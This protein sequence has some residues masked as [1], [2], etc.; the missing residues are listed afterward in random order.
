MTEVNKEAAAVAPVPLFFTV[1][2]SALCSLFVCLSVWL[3]LVEPGESCNVENITKYR[4]CMPCISAAVVLLLW[5]GV[6][7]PR[8]CFF[9]MLVSGMLLSVA[10]YLLFFMICGHESYSG[11]LVSWLLGAIAWWGLSLIYS[12]TRES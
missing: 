11:L 5:V 9:G 1:V 8:L 10:Q 6:R 12:G 4:G 7:R 3:M 2:M